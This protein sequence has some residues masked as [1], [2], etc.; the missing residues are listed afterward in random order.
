MVIGLENGDHVGFGDDDL[1]IQNV[2]VGIVATVHHEGKVDHESR[3]VALAVGASVGVVGGQTVV[4][5][6]LSLALAVDDD[7]TACAFHLRSEVD[8]AAD[9]V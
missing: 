6:K 9:G 7:A 8:P 4:C 3:G 2:V 1:P 5:Q